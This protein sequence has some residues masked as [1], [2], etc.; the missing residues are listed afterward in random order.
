MNT[1]GLS[2][3]SFSLPISEVGLRKSEASYGDDSPW[4]IQGIASTPDRDQQGEIVLL[5]GLDLSYLE[6]GKGTFNWNHFGDKDPSS[7]IGVITESQKTPD[8]QLYVSGRLLKNLPKARACYELMKALESEGEQRRMGMSVEGKI[9]HREHKVIYKAWVK[10]VALTMDP[11]NPN[12]YV[13]F[14][15]SFSGATLA[16]EDEP[17][18]QITPSVLERALT[19]AGSMDGSMPNPRSVLS[20]EHL[21]SNVVDLGFDAKKR[22]GKK[23]LK[24]DKHF[25]GLN[26]DEAV[27]HLVTLA[28]QLSTGLAAGIVRL[29]LRSK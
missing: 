6:E 22:N 25:Q 23:L 20:K 15:K 26:Y 2:I 29:A 19:I 10:A 7:V 8:R 18:A 14:A 28:P 16:E 4:L 1:D 13:S 27:Q 9:L 17:L 24:S 5:D 12:T 3:T 21:E 11:V